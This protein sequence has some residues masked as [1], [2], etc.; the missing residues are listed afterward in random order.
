MNLYLVDYGS[1]CAPFSRHIT[2]LAGISE[3]SIGN[4]FVRLH[5]PASYVSF[6]GVYPQFTSRKDIIRKLL[7]CLS[8]G[9]E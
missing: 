2:L 9:E 5:F 6:A 7:G 1:A 8:E 4:A 3:F